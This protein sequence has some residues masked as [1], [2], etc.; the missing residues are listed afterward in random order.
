MF[1]P[2]GFSLLV[3]DYWFES[4]VTGDLYATFGHR[5]IYT[6]GEAATFIPH[7]SFLIMER[8]HN[9]KYGNMVTF[10]SFPFL[11]ID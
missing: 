1:F 10:K 4:G 6:R 2:Y 3:V 7:S 5:L 8:N 11:P 9:P